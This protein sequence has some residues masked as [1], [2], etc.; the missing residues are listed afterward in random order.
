M[1]STVLNAGL[2]QSRNYFFYLLHWTHLIHYALL[3]FSQSAFFSCTE[4]QFHLNLS[5]S[6]ILKYFKTL[7]T[8]YA[9]KIEIQ[10]PNIFHFKAF[11]MIN[12]QYEIKICQKIYNR[13]TMTV[14][15]KFVVRFN[16]HKT[17]P[18]SYYLDQNFGFCDKFM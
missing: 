16:V 13:V 6:Y 11:S 9:R 15:V 7:I 18:S 1:L 10:R 17:L 5:K 14:Y 3:L 2:L 8:S 12:L 4:D